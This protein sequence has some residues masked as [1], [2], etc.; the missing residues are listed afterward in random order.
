MKQQRIL[1]RLTRCPLE[2]LDLR[3]PAG[4]LLPY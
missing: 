4:L 1:K 2:P 3:S